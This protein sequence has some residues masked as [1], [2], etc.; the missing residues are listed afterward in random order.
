MILCVILDTIIIDAQIAVLAPTVYSNEL[1]LCRTMKVEGIPVK[2]FEP[3]V[4]FC[5]LLYKY[6]KVWF[7]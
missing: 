2:S 6:H 7:C 4:Q 3:L 5:P 1:V